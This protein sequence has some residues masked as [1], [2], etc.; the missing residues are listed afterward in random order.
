LK[1]IGSG[2]A[3]FG[4]GKVGLGASVDDIGLGSGL[5]AFG[6]GPASFGRD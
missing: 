5:K 6:A 3:T 4:A 1:D 2:L